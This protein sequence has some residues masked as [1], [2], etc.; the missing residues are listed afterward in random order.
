M[1]CMQVAV[2]TVQTLSVIWRQMCEN[3]E[4]MQQ[5]NLSGNFQGR[6]ELVILYFSA[7]LP[8]Y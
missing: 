8:F 4:I 5:I 7:L 2:K 3:W 1:F 6:C